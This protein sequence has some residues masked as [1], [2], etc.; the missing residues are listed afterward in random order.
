MARTSNR[1]R[2]DTG[3]LSYQTALLAVGLIVA[4]L[5]TRLG[6]VV[7]C[8]VVI[9]W[10]WSMKTTRKFRAVHWALRWITVVVV[11]I[12]VSAMLVVLVRD[13]RQQSLVR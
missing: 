4:G 8:G 11:I 5:I 12:I 10:W 3:V 6:L 13:L 9:G 2:P 1:S 7:D